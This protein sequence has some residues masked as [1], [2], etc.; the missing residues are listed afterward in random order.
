[1]A[2]G[3]SI[4]GDLVERFMVARVYMLRKKGREHQ[5][6]KRPTIIIQCSLYLRQNVSHQ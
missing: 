6:P 3:N 4:P 5:G 1:M 2:P